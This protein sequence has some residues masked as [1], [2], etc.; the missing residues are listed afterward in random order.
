[1]HIPHLH[2]H[3]SLPPQ[4][5]YLQ[6]I[7]SCVSYALGQDAPANPLK[8]VAG[9]E[10]ENTNI[11]LQMLA[12]AAK[13]GPGVAAVQAV[14]GG[15]PPIQR[16]ASKREA[17][18]AE[19][20]PAPAPVPAPEPV[21]QA[22]PPPIARTSSRSRV[23]EPPT[24]AP[25]AAAPAAPPPSSLMPPP[26][27]PAPGGIARPQSAK[28]APPR[29]PRQDLASQGMGIGA[30]PAKP[31]A[32]VVFKESANDDDDD[33]AELE[34]VQETSGRPRNRGVPVDA[35]RAGALVKDMLNAEKQLAGEE[36]AGPATEAGVGGGIKLGGRRKAGKAGGEGKDDAGVIREGIQQL[37]QSTN[38]LGRYLEL[39][40]E[41]SDS[42][43][44]ELAFWRDE[45]RASEQKL[46]ELAKSDG[47]AAESKSASL[48]KKLDEE[49]HAM[50][51]SIHALKSQILA[52]DDQI[53]R[54]LTTITK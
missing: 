45:R 28:K 5:A 1:M 36:E 23:E 21:A 17:P 20:A 53:T 43:A 50:R 29:A 35:S 26:S 9:L 15:K 8:I 44:K 49:I 18:P 38:P 6:K 34:V 51:S 32:P 7:I 47:P 54:L 39:L 12:R 24:P 22:A 48:V 27:M 16:Q 2:L 30:G 52:N 19:P 3:H 42:M 4:V 37:C 31:N 40:A 46:E 25:A 11:F 33:D 10:A 41:D 14:L 13:E